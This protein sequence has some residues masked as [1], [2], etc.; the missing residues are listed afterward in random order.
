M[1]AHDFFNQIGLAVDI[2]APGGD[3]HGDSLARSLDTETKTLENGEALLRGDFQTRQ[4]LDFRQREIDDLGLMALITND[5]GFAG[6][7]AA[8]CQNQFGGALQTRNH[9]FRIDTTLET[10]TRIGD[11]AERTAG[12]GNVDRIPESRLDEHVDG[13]FGAA[14]MLPAHDAADRL[15]A[16]FVGNDDIVRA[17]LVFTLVEREDR[18][19]LFRTANREIALD[20]GGVEDVH[21]PA[22]IEGHVVGDINES[23]D[24]TQADRHQALLHPFRAG[25]ILHAAHDAQRKAGAKRR[26]IQFQLHIDGGCAFN[27]EGRR[28]LRLQLTQTG[29][30]EIAGDAVDRSAV[31][32]VGREVDLDDRII[33]ASIGCEGSADRRIFRQIDDAVVIVGN[34]ELLF[35]AHHAVAFDAANLADG[36]RHIDARNIHAG[37]SERTNEAGACIRRAA[38]DLHRLAVTSIHHQHLEAV[39]LGMFFSGNDLGDDERLVGRL[40]IDVLDLEAN[41]RQPLANLVQRRIRFEMLFQPGKSEFHVFAPWLTGLNAQT[42]E[43]RRHVERAEAVMV[44]PADIGV[45]EI[46][47]IRHAVFQHGDAVEAHAPGKALIFIRVQPTGAQHVRV[48]HA[49]A[50]DFHPVLAFAELDDGAGTVALDIHLEARLREG[51]ERR[52]KAHDDTVDLE[53]GLAEFFENP[54]QIADMRLL[55]DDKAF[56]LMEHRRMG[57][58]GVLTIGLARNDD[59]DRRLLTFHG[60][61]LH[62]RGVGAQHLALAVFIRLEEEGVVHFAGRMAFGEIQRR[63]V[64][65]VGLDVRT[66]GDREPHIREDGSNFIDDLAYG[67]NAT[68]LGRRLTNRQADIHRFR[69]Q[70]GGN[71][72]VLQR[73]LTLADEVGDF[74]L[75]LVDGS[76]PGLALFRRHA[77]KRLQKLRNRAFLAKCGNTHGL[78]GRLISGGGDLR[79]QLRFQGIKFSHLFL[80]C[81]YF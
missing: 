59:A 15:E 45:E 4:A 67:M 39:G 8:Q 38:D 71:G 2:R 27:L 20:L 53:E 52:A 51:E 29:G 14:G 35:G 65:I 32:T 3:G 22:L 42:A 21:R 80:P 34:V 17:E 9:I 62:R 73:V 11:D 18:L 68:A 74:G 69:F 58:V 79:H 57:R 31:R 40:V 49:A 47:Q 41:R 25:A 16:L 77:A 54:A 12:L 6:N 64:V 66:F 50:E 61:D 36:Q 10:I 33:E 75:E 60:A 30:G 1:D 5:A 23:I 72:G 26:I 37:T 70:P 46:A 55:V 13:V 81:R 28:R 78:D 44:H 43:Q 56:D 48:H 63:E 7:A 76:A 19:T 24:R